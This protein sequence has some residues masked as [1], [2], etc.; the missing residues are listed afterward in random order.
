MFPPHQQQQIRVQ[1]ANVLEAVISQQ[2]IPTA[3]GSGRVAAFEVLHSNPAVRNLIREG[4]THLLQSAIETAFKDGMMTLQ[5]SLEN[6]YESGII[7]HEET[8]K[9][10]ADYQQPKPY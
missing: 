8:L 10:S 7:A 3:D 6:L 5:K 1:L 2:L 4:K 9:Y